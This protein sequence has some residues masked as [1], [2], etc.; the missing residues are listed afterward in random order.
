MVQEQGAAGEHESGVTAG[1]ERGVLQG[2]L[3]TARLQESEVAWGGA[4]V[5]GDPLIEDYRA[6]IGR[7]EIGN[8]PGNGERAGAVAESN[9]ARFVDT[10]DKLGAGA[11]HRPGGHVEDLPGAGQ[12]DGAIV[13][14][15]RP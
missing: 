6:P 14:G 11:G 1:S 8:G 5:A 3:T 12:D 4:N 10:A 2:D 15:A 7:I 13:V 9:T